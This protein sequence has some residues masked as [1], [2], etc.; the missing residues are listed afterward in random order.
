MILEQTDEYK[1]EIK[2]ESLVPNVNV[3]PYCD[4]IKLVVHFIAIQSTF[5]TVFSSLSQRLQ[6]DIDFIFGLKKK[7]A[8]SKLHMYIFILL[9]S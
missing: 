6:V 1:G 3:R 9:I 2:I 5:C 4:R 7:I 8:Q